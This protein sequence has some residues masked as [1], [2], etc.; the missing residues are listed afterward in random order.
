[1]VSAKNV[2]TSARSKRTTTANCKNVEQFFLS[3]NV[4]MTALGKG[5]G[6][7][8]GGECCGDET[9]DLLR[10]QG[11]RD[12]ATL[13]RHNSMSLQ[14]LLS[15]TAATLQ[16]HV[17]DLSRQ[18]E[19]KTLLLF[20]QVY[21]GMAVLSRD[22]IKTLY[23]DIR[24]YILVN[25]TQ[26]EISTGI[27]IKAS[28]SQFF[29][30]FFPLV[31]H[32]ILH[33]NGSQDFAPDYKVCLKKTT[34][35]ILPFGE[36]PKQVSQSL[37]KSLEATRLLLQAFTIGT[38]VLNTTGRLLVDEGG[39]SNAECH[40]ALLKMTYCPKCQGLVKH[41][42]PCS[43]YCL[44]VLRGCL[45]KYVA[46]LDSPWNG[47]VEGIESLI[48]AMKKNKEDA[49]V[50]ADAAIRSLDTKISESIM[51]A[52]QKGKDIDAKVQR[53]CGPATFVKRKDPP[54][55]ETSTP[56]PATSKPRSTSA[57][58]YGSLPETQLLHFLTSIARTRGF[59]GNLADTLCQDENFAE[60]RD[61]R[62]WNGERIAEYTK[63]VVDVG[64]DMQKYNPEVKPM[65]NLQNV[66]PR[67][68]DL[69]DKLRHV[70]HMAMSSLGSSGAEVDY[71]QR[72][73]VEGSG[74]GNGADFEDNDEEY[75]TRGSG[76]G[77]GP[78]SEGEEDSR[79]INPIFSKGGK[80]TMRPPTAP[81]GEAS[82][83]KSSLLVSV[84]AVALARLY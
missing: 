57:R 50:N 63:T 5:K 66:D 28:V 41:A 14:G 81:T 12:F 60:P 11:Q 3:R 76:S 55:D 19:N 21:K 77:Y 17:S 48:N 47:Y 16:N 18:S 67:V 69:V 46:E 9:E 83:V 82:T 30:D 78:I 43:G 38:E 70:H 64:L 26:A 29:T 52:M 84:V 27:D 32:H 42:K 36:I 22:P 37:S 59:Y 56:P 68:A 74:S 61:Q 24:N 53:N 80:S 72:D 45:T 2:E 15:F 62:C 54:A 40:E 34:E 20:T 13:L 10:K 6:S 8:C 49:G 1:M 65:T 25:T 23:S 75:N 51:R 39:K 44:N 71:M 4:S 33:I 31:Y 58:S 7:V 79:N 35:T 73:G